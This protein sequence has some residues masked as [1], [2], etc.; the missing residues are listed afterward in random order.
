MVNAGQH[1]YSNH[2][3]GRNNNM[4]AFECQARRQIRL[5]RRQNR[6]EELVD[7]RDYPPKPGKSV[8]V[9]QV[10][11]KLHFWCILYTVCTFF[12]QVMDRFP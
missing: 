11:E 5:L 8:F 6:L 1:L 10:T 12:E 9:V 7:E 3:R 4:I 2:W